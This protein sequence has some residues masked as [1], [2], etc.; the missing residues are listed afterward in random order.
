VP[1]RRTEAG[2]PVAPVVDLDWA[3]EDLAE[4]V[5]D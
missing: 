5:A 2:L 4:L 1:G 3:G